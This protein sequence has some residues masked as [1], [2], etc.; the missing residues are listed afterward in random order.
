MGEDLKPEDFPAEEKS[1]DDEVWEKNFNKKTKLAVFTFLLTV[2]A[3]AVL[4]MFENLRPN[5]M[6]NGVKTPMDV[7]SMII[8]LM[9]SLSAI[10]IFI[11][12]IKPTKIYEE[13]TFRMGGNIITSIFG[14]SWISS[15]FIAC[16][17]NLIM[18]FV[19]SMGAEHVWIFGFFV[20]I[21]SVFITSHT[22]SILTLFPLGVMLGISPL[23]LLALIPAI[24]SVFILPS[25]PTIQ[26]ALDVDKTGSTHV[27]KFLINHSFIRPGMVAVVVGLIVA[28]LLVRILC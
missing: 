13:Q 19:S 22:A 1:F 5:V 23:S 7:S 6:I 4:G 9:F 8:I 11:C 27:G 28:H 2:I 15:T 14:I 24:D 26:V 3:I 20:F 25:F 10:I 18:S 16:N 12:G 17:K 21:L